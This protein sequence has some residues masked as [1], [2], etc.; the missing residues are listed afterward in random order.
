MIWPDTTS[1][2]LVNFLSTTAL[3]AS[4]NSAPA[5]Q[6]RRL[7]RHSPESGTIST[8]KRKSPRT[9]IVPEGLAQSACRADYQLTHMSVDCISGDRRLDRRYDFEMDVRFSYSERGVIYLGAG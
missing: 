3:A 8:E 6:E 7:A 2:S 9:P 4:W 1:T 5:D